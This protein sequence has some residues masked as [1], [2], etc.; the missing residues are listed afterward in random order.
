MSKK[1]AGILPF[2][3]SSRGLEVFLV[4]PGGPLWAKKDDGAWSL[5]KG[6]FEDEEPILAARREFEEET[7]FLLSGELIALGSLRQSGGK[8]VHAWA[9]R[10]DLD[11]G[12]VRSNHFTM[13]WPPRSGKRQTF[14]EIDR[15][16][17]FSLDVARTKI[18]RGQSG[19]LDRL[20]S[21]LHD[22]TET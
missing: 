11:T 17:W 20:E 16:A 14:P 12:A 22:G 3:E 21:I 10:G 7:G 1:S 13:E 4:H 19:F 15:A 18:L 6:E 2:R 5:P 9:V 8:I